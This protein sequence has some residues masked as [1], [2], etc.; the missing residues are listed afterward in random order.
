MAGVDS[1]R[2]GGS[3]STDLVM[4]VMNE[5][6][7]SQGYA[8]IASFRRFVVMKGKDGKFVAIERERMNSKDVFTSCR[9]ILIACQMERKS[10]VTREHV[11][12]W[13]DGRGIAPMNHL[14]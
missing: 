3:D 1:A 2:G 7:S 9:R 10:A 6:R 5:R 12:R 14:N 4:L 11:T 8:C 13:Q